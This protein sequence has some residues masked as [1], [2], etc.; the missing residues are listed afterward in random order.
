MTHIADTFYRL[1]HNYVK[2]G[3]NEGQEGVLLEEDPISEFFDLSVC[4]KVLSI[5]CNVDPVSGE[6]TREEQI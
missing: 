2:S 3:L 4:P 6:I 1:L 5:P